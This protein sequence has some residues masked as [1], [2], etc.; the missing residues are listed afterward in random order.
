[1]ITYQD[2]LRAGQSDADRAEFAR[3][4][5]QDYKTG[6]QYNVASIA[7]DYDRG[8]NTT[9]TNYQKTL[10]TLT[11][12]VIPDQ[13]S[14]THRSASNYFAIFTTQLCQYLLGNGAEWGDDGTAEKLGADFDNR[15]QQAGKAALCAGVAYGFWNFDHMEVF[16]ALEFAPLYD[17]ENGSLSAGVRFWQIDSTKPLRAT[18]YEMDGYTDFL[19]DKNNEPGE[20][21]HAV[22]GSEDCYFREKRPYVLIFRQSEAEGTEI[23]A[24]ENY[25]TFPIVPLYGNPRKQSE[26]IGLREKIDAYDMIL[27]GYEDD[28]DNAQLYWIIKGA[29]GM[30]DV[31]LAQFL[32]RLRTVRAAAPADGQDVEAREINIPVEA[33]E[34]L[35]DRLDKQLYRDAMILNPADIAAGAATA[36]QI[37]AAYE[38]QNVK[39]D[40]FEYCVIDFL[41][42]VCRVAGVDDS[43]TFT[44]SVIVNTQ[45]EVTTVIAAAQFLGEEYVTRKVLNLLGDGD[46]ADDVIEQM[47]ADRDD[48]LTGLDEGEKDE[49]EKEQEDKEET[50][51]EK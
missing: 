3:K 30:D 14:P 42:G 17:E 50:A 6:P 44:R 43:P 33:R 8:L 46:I 35:L 1:M 16:T 20:P 15:L 7:D 11:G 9:I 2:L 41:S 29:G 21:W 19:W 39:A 47:N 27:N 26:L 22:E 25:P 51:E 32:D 45:E 38:P 12:K 36:T 34:R 23:Y 37:K 31:D 48:R 5:I 49:E 18:L 28:L 40:Q 13:W 10:T 4:V 24:G